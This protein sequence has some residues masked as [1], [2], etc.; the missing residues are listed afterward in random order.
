VNIKLQTF[1]EQSSAS[2]SDWQMASLGELS[3]QLQD[4][5]GDV[6]YVSRTLYP[7][8]LEPFGLCIAL[9]QLGSDLQSHRTPVGVRCDPSLAEARFQV[10]TEIELFRI[11]QEAVSNALRH[12]R[13]RRV[14]LS[15]RY[16]KG[17]LRLTVLDNG[18]GFDTK[19]SFRRG[20]APKGL[21]LISMQERAE[22]IGG[23][24][25]ITSRP[26]RT[27]VEVRAPAQKRLPASNA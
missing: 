16:A 11:A 3:R 26:G 21:G 22:E 9:K 12:G 20:A 27:C 23:T 24:L 19:N 18:K 25:R 2:L 5:F 13:P 6:R 4:V 14:D 8:T 10:E 7:P 17:I 15:L 1:A